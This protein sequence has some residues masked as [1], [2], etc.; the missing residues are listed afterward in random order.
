M[1][2]HIEKYWDDIPVGRE[3][4]I[5]YPE[6]Q[7]KWECGERTVR[8]ILHDLSYA[9]NGDNMILIR[10]SA[11]KGLYK[12][13]NID[14]IERYK[15]E[16]INRARNNFAPLRKIRRVLKERENNDG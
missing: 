6:L 10:S 9:D 8:Q 13:D 4:A 14:I 1:E 3:N 16:C 12:T 11:S 15:K 7:S 5:T 2:K